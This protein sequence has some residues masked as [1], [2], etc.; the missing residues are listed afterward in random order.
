M[1]ARRVAKPVTA[2]AANKRH[3]KLNT[4]L[5]RRDIHVYSMTQ[6]VRGAR[7]TRERDRPRDDELCEKMPN[8]G[9]TKNAG[10]FPPTTRHDDGGSFEDDTDAKA[11][12]IATTVSAGSYFMSKCPRLCYSIRRCG[13]NVSGGATILCVGTSNNTIKCRH[14]VGRFHEWSR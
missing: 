2:D 7:I 12:S 6:R 11:S 10:K 1:T 5:F 9:Q 13:T 8:K 3:A 4:I 14:F